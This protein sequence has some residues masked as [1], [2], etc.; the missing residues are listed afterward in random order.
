MVANTDI[1]KIIISNDHPDSVVASANPSDPVFLEHALFLHEHGYFK[2]IPV[3]ELR[4]KLRS[5]YRRKI[6]QKPVIPEDVWK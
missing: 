1:P 6:A 2:E 4:E 5:L 3:Q